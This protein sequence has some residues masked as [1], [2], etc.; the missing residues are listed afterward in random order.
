MSPLDLT[1]IAEKL[2]I[3]IRSGSN[4]PDALHLRSQ[5]GMTEAIH[6]A[7]QS[8]VSQALEEAARDVVEDAQIDN[9]PSV[10]TV[11]DWLRARA[12][13]IRKEER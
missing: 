4:T 1:E 7:L 8:A 6:Q 12:A 5:E 9:E 3:R 13:Q 11:A 2:A 10:F